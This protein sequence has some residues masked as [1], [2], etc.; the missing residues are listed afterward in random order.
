MLAAGCR[1]GA[2]TGT[3]GFFLSNDALAEDGKFHDATVC[4]VDVAAHLP[5]L[6]G[7]GFYLPYPLALMH[8]MAAMLMMTA[9]VVN[10][11]ANILTIAIFLILGRL[12]ANFLCTR[13]TEKFRCS[14]LFSNALRLF[15]IILFER[16]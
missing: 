4:G 5:Y 2:V 16:L 12:E 9:T 1:C 7:L 3:V 11:N 10:T 8:Q 13:L 14:F 6:G 15:R